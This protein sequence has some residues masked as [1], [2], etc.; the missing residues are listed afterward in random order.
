[1]DFNNSNISFHTTLSA[2]CSQFSIN[3]ENTVKMTLSGPSSYMYLKLDAEQS[4]T[5]N[6]LAR[7][8]GIQHESGPE[9]NKFMVYSATFLPGRIVAKSA[10]DTPEEEKVFG[11]IFETATASI[12][13]QM[14]WSVGPADVAKIVLEK[15][16]KFSLNKPKRAC[17]L[18]IELSESAAARLEL[19]K[20]NRF[21]KY[22][23]G[24]DNKD[25][26]CVVVFPGMH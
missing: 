13:K 21:R 14:G 8:I 11:Q 12:A 22:G 9:R 25:E 3:H 24:S 1:M 20:D 15:T 2:A 16:V 4:Q 7:K 17:S 18:S 6:E 10:K 5:V 26:V 23:T 19:D